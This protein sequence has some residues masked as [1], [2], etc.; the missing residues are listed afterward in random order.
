MTRSFKV[1]TRIARWKLFSEETELRTSG[2][3][4]IAGRYKARCCF[5]KCIQFFVAHDFFPV[6]ED[7]TQTHLLDV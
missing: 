7:F 1:G 2:R 6:N 5:K 4:K 3:V